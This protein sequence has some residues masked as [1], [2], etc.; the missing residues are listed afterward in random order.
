MSQPDI[1][2]CSSCGEHTGFEETED[3]WLSECCGATA[4]DTDFEPA[5]PD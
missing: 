5:D 2:I 1:D 4:Y 3:G